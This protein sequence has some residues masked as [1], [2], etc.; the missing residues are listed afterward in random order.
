MSD[1]F[2][3]YLSNKVGNNLGEEE[4]INLKNTAMVNCQ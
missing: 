2:K 4:I 3:F 1:K